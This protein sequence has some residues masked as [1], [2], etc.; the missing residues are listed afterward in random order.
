MSTRYEFPL[1]SGSYFAFRV[2]ATDNVGNEAGG[3]AVCAPLS[4][5]LPRRSGI[6][7]R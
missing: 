3:E 5:K 2:T 4:G 7:V 6:L 1:S